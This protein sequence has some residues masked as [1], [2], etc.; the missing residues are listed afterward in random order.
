MGKVTKTLL[1]NCTHAAIENGDMD[2]VLEI[3]NIY[4]S[5]PIFETIYYGADF[6]KLSYKV[7]VPDGVGA[8]GEVDSS[9]E[10]VVKIYQLFNGRSEEVQHSGNVAGL[11]HGSVVWVA[12][13]SNDF[14]K[15][16]DGLTKYELEAKI[17]STE[18]LLE[19]LKKQLL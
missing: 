18:K 14:I 3:S 6:D 12:R 4:Y 15:F 11:I 2:T 10:S 1:Y 16:L 5:C 9:V 7:C 17:K 19:E 13:R 8:F